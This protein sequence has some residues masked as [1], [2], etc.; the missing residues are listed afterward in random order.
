M[1]LLSHKK[2]FD[3]LFSGNVITYYSVLIGIFILAKWL[4]ILLNGEIAEGKYEISLHIF[5]EFMM[6]AISILS[7]FMI[8]KKMNLGFMMNLIAQSMI[9][10]SVLNAMGY[11]IELREFKMVPLLILILISSLYFLISLLYF[12]IN[13][14]FIKDEN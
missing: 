9:L 10:Y 13:S 6:A 14:K 11:Y 8:F 7:G 1:I 12:I 4:S 2:L 5:S 3:R